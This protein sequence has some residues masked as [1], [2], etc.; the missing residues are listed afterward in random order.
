[1][2]MNASPVIVKVP[3]PVQAGALPAT[4]WVSRRLL[5][6]AVMLGFLWAVPV[7]VASYPEHTALWLAGI[8]GVVLVVTVVSRVF[9][10]I[11]RNRIPGALRLYGMNEMPRRPWIPNAIA[12]LVEIV[13]VI[14]ALPY[15]ISRSDQ[16]GVLAGVL[17]LFGAILLTFGVFNATAEL[18]NRLPGWKWE[19]VR[20]LAGSLPIAVTLAYAGL[21]VAPD[22]YDTAPQWFWIG[23]VIAAVGRIFE[24]MIRPFGREVIESLDDAADGLTARGHIAPTLRDRNRMRAM[25]RASAIAVAVLLVGV[26][27]LF[28][29]L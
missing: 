13:V 9:R 10:R 24:A 4:L 1:M 6:F 19:A 18:W 27:G 11:E 25:L 14:V 5:N 20:S 7:A 28:V 17:A 15:L 23:L 16:Y 2:V 8:L 21:A 26:F 12:N 22:P 29:S 3:H